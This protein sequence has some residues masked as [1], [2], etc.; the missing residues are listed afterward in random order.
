MADEVKQKILVLLGPTGVG[1]S[2]LAIELAKALNAEIVMADSQSVLKGFDIG[3]AKPSLEER[4]EVPH[5][6]LDVAEFGEVFDAARFTFLADQTIADIVARG[7]IPLISGGTGLYLKALLHGFMEAPSRNE[8]LRKKLEE[9]ISSEGLESLYQEL[10]ALDRERA[11]E[12]H[13]N[14]ALRIIRALEIYQE[15]GE[16]PSDLARKHRFQGSK[17]EALKIGLKLPR[18]DL[19]QRIDHR[20]LTMLNQG[21]VEEVKSLLAR[22][23]DLL[24]GRTQTIGYPTLARLVNGE[25]FVNDAIDEIQRETR[26]L[27]KRQLAW[28]RA[29]KEIRW[30]HPQDFEPILAECRRFLAG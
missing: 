4:A 18:E 19:Y 7:K 29:D 5:H 26:Q 25:V 1:K 6:L 12:I 28:F 30:F 3:T 16:K 23:Y 2:A 10:Q 9:R 13:P 14:D 15:S 24:Q 20:V 17:Y 21:W 22:G 27:A 8:E 11:A